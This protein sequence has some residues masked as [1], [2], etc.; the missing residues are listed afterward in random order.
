MDSV[1]CLGCFNFFIPRNKLQQYCKKPEC[2]KTRKAKWQYQKLK[3][4]REYRESQH[5]SN[6]KWLAQ[7]PDYWK[8]YRHKNPEK[9]IRNRMLQRVRNRRQNDK[10]KIPVVTIIA[11][12]DARKPSEIEPE[13]GFWLVPTIAK[14]DARKFY[15]HLIPNS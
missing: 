4:D 7:T 6:Q 5:W 2:Q 14:M 11:K 1:P 9:T 10:Q 13:G 3:N 15:F 8:H 12:M